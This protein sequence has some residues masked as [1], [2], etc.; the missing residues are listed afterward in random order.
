MNNTKQI[1]EYILG[2]SLNFN[3]LENRIILGEKG[4]KINIVFS[5]SPNPID[6]I[7]LFRKLV[8]ERNPII[9]LKDNF[10]DQLFR[11]KDLL[12]F[13]PNFQNV[14]TILSPNPEKE[15]NH[16][17][18]YDLPAD[19]FEIRFFDQTKILK[20]MFPGQEEI[21][22][23]DRELSQTSVCHFIESVL[24]QDSFNFSNFLVN[25]EIPKTEF[26]L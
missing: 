5:C 11:N 23:L 22:N 18:L 24:L 19:L 10:T 20:C 26:A 17:D 15:H 2:D 13:L 16:I 6:N 14:L 9:W 1:L 8:E 25:S 7:D 21:S 3:I 12:E 4:R